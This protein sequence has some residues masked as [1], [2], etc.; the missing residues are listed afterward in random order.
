MKDPA[1]LFY[2]SDFLNGVTDLTMEERGQY[3]TMLC[4]QHQKGHLTEKMIRLCVGN[5]T[6]DVLAKFSQ[7]DD[8]N[9]FNDRM[10]LEINKRKVHAEKQRDR[11]I[12]GWKKRKEEMPRH[13]HG[14]ATAMPLENENEN[15]IV[16]KSVIRK[17]SAE[18]K[19]TNP[20]S[21]SFLQYWE[22]W[23]DYKKSS[24]RFSYKT[25]DSENI[26]LAQL[27]KSSQGNEEFAIE[28]IHHSIAQGY[29]GIFAPDKSKQKSNGKIELTSKFA[30]WINKD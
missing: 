15:V 16:S 27:A 11:A 28:M 23:K 20:F 22:Q 14:N 7:D 19:P 1:I 30:E 25:I 21:D 2:T 12:E 9:Y 17:R 4:V 10:E 18:E 26:A 24:H 6:A 13:N 8:G 3:I 29:K 5:A